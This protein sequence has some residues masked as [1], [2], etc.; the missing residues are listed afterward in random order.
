MDKLPHS[1]TV[2][3]FDTYRSFLP[4]AEQWMEYRRATNNYNITV[5]VCFVGQLSVKFLV[6]PH[7]FHADFQTG[8]RT[9]AVALSF[10]LLSNEILFLWGIE[11]K[12]MFRIYNIRC[13]YAI[14]AP[15]RK[16]LNGNSSGIAELPMSVITTFPCF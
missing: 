1:E 16:V 13:C 9:V 11:R 15:L 7:A 3:R 2:L 5:L 4:D 14:L 6:L 10:V 8:N 12:E